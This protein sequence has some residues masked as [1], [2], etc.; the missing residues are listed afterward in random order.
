MSSGGEDGLFPREDE[1]RQQESER[2]E[3]IRKDIFGA[4]RTTRQQIVHYLFLLRVCLWTTFHFISN[5]AVL[6]C[7]QCPQHVGVFEKTDCSSLVQH[8]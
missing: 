4:D 6:F 5:L 1:E 2:K 3:E 8:K 7:Y